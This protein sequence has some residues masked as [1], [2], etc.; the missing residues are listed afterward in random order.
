[1]AQFNGILSMI[2]QAAQG[3]GAVGVPGAGLVGTAL[4]G[5][6][7]LAEAFDHFKEA[8]GGTAPP[9]AQAV[10]D[11]KLAAVLAHAESTASRLDG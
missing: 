7:K 6:A 5:G 4:K 11:G 1:M 10:R 3:L 9:E 2:A 8:N